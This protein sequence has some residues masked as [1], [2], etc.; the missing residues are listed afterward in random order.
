MLALLESLPFDDRTL[1][2]VYRDWVAAG[3]ALGRVVH[4]RA[5][6]QA[7]LASGGSA[8]P[9][10][11]VRAARRQWVSTVV[12]F[13]RVLDLLDLST[14]AREALIAPL[15]TSVKAVQSARYRALVATDDEPE[16]ITQ[17]VHLRE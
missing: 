7:S 6:I 9:D 3:K 14:E 2:D 11:D 17:T 4:Q 10:V 12:T 8:A 5:R 15:A 13:L 16:S 1:A